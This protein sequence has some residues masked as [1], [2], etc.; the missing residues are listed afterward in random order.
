MKDLFK[1]IL[2]ILASLF[3]SRAKLEAEILI[4]RQQINLLRRQAPKR[5]HFNNTDRF[6]FVWLYRQFPSVLGAIAIVRP[7]TIIRWHRAGFRAYWRWRSRNHVGRPK[8]SAELRTL[9]GEMSRANS[10]WGAPHIHGE[11]LKLGFDVAQSTVARHMCRPS[12]PPSQGWRTF[13][14]N[15]A[16]GIAAVDLFV[17]PTIASGF[18]IVLSSYGMDDEFGCRLA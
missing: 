2:G 6:L 4:L 5:P 18:S 14:S 8:V 15:H 17:L 10:L 9:I 11:L 16:G 12:R 13:L 1:L 7:E 3:K